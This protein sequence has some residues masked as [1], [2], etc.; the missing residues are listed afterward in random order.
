PASVILSAQAREESRKA[1]E[2]SRR[3]PTARE[4]SRLGNARR[5]KEERSPPRR[6]YGGGT[7][8][9]QLLPRMH[10]VPGS[11]RPLGGHH[12]PPRLALALSRRC[13][14]RLRSRARRVS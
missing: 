9:R 1:L 7:G 5:T 8:C 10:A 3:A 4:K 14:A 13:R 2:E 12:V 6:R 11:L